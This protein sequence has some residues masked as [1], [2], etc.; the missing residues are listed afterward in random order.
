MSI[1]DSKSL[2]DAVAK[3]LADANVPDA[4]QNAFALV[5]TT[6]GGVKGVLTTKIN[7]V[8]Q[9]DSVFSVG[10]DKHF[11]GGVQIKATWA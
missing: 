1:F 7:N 3:S 9:I 11:D 6:S 5:A 2:A 8:W 10:H 4:H